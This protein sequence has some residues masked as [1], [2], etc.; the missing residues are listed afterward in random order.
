MAYAGF[1]FGENILKALR[2]EEG[3]VQ[4]AFVESSLTDAQ[5]FASP[6]KFGRHGVEEVLPFGS[7]SPDEKNALDKLIPELVTHIQKGIDY[8]VN[9]QT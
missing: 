3:I 5:F 6:C 4:C 2:G 9:Q 1:L 7:I 8:I